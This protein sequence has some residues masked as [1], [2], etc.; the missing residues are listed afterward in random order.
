MAS[1]YKYLGT[2]LVWLL[3]IIVL[4]SCSSTRSASFYD[5]DFAGK[6]YR[7]VCVMVDIP[8]VDLKADIEGKVCRAIAERT[9]GKVEV[10]PGGSIQVL[11]QC[12]DDSVLQSALISR[13]I[14]C[15]LLITIDNM[16]YKEKE[17]IEPIENED[18][19]EVITV[20]NLFILTAMVF[21]LGASESFTDFSATIIDTESS[22]E[23]WMSSFKSESAGDFDDVFDSFA[24]EIALKME[25]DGLFR[26]NKP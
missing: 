14:D 25:S 26:D 18:A 22:S 5:R 24:D 10:T 19:N 4:P 2:G 6:I 7:H 23:I 15:Y 1:I 21:Q 13:G 12:R 8:E 9:N 16:V 3:I 17:P 20:F 11:N